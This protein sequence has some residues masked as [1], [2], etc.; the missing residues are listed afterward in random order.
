MERRNNYP[1]IL[2]HGFMG[3]GDEDGLS[4]FI[5]GWGFSFTKN[6]VKHL[7]NCGYECYAPACGPVNNLWDRACELWY[8]LVGG[9][10]DYGKYHSELY[11]H[12]RYGRTYPGVLK[13]WGTPGD[14]A[15]INLVGH[16]FGGPTARVLAQ[17]LAYGSKE[18]QECTPEEE[19]S[20]LFK[21]GKAD[22]V[23]SITTL[24]G[25]NNGTTLADFMRVGG[26][27]AF[28]AGYFGIATML[29]ESPFNS[30]LI[31]F[32]LE[33]W[34]I[35][36]NPES[37]KS[38]YLHSPFS[39]REE[40][41]NYNKNRR[42]GIV[43]EMQEK[44][45]YELNQELSAL[46]NVYYFARPACAS[47]EE[48]GK[49]VVNKDASLMAK[50][51][52]KLTFIGNK[53]GDPKY[54]YNPETWLPHDGFVNTEAARAPYSEPSADWP[55]DDVDATTLKPG[56]WYVFEPSDFD[57]TGLMGMGAP[58]AKYHGYFQ[59]VAEQVSALPK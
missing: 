34:G 20:D 7:N 9:K 14:H 47:H 32:H 56:I 4:R 38:L 16:S 30:Q 43:F 25:V 58:K 59:S 31:D 6:A 11:G 1:I 17:L 37:K 8:H 57:H 3:Y 28:Q 44:Y 2:V 39:K 36:A 52:G 48:N 51:V 50:L 19:L 26:A 18:E 15:K 29:G 41:K 21:G 35:M 27:K 12:K 54:G 40:I 5:S 24:A 13:D 23:R 42:G 33:Q 46:P 10:V 22:W 45:I 55:G 53:Y 49:W